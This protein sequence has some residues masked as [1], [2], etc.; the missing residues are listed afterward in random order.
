MQ[1]GEIE[2]AINSYHEPESTQP[3][4]QPSDVLRAKY[5][6]TIE[7]GASTEAYTVVCEVH[8][9]MHVSLQNM[10]ESIHHK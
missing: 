4:L 3:E 7:L 2:D 5:A 10:I 8:V 6:K 9:F 1:V